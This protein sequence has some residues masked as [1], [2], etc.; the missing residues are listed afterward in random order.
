MREM[1]GDI[2]SLAI[3][4][5][6]QLAITSTLPKGTPLTVELQT[7]G[8]ILPQGVRLTLRDKKKEIDL[9]VGNYSIQA[10][11]PGTTYEL[12]VIAE[13]PKSGD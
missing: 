1:R 8:T 9:K 13:Q 11:G 7:E 6:W 4:Q 3:K 10:P 5:E 12:L 2:R